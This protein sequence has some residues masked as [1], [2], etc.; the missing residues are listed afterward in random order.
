[1][2]SPPFPL[3]GAASP[4]AD[5]T[6]QCY[7]SFR[8]SQDEIAASASSS[9]KASSR[10]LPS[11]AETKAMNTHHRRW[12]PSLDHPTPTLH[13]CKKVIS[14][15]VSPHHSTTSLFCLLPSQSTM[16]LELHPSLSFPFTSVPHP[17]SLCTMTPTVM[18]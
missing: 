11:R 17:S 7:A 6:M 5:V 3:R 10:R 13:C 12:P 14:T 1:M 2:S 16:P 8:L 4:L 15:L 18:N 9:G